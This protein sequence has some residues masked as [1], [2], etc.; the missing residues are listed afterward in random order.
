MVAATA[1]TAANDAHIDNYAYEIDATDQPGLYRIDWPNAAF[2][3]AY[4]EV[5]LSVVLSGSF[6]EHLRVE[7]S[8]PVD[9]VSLGGG[10]AAALNLKTAADAWS[11]T[12]GMSGT[13]LPAAVAGDPGGLPL[14][15]AGSL[16]LDT[17]LANTNEITVARMGALT[18]WIDGGRLDL[19]LDAIKAVTDVLNDPTAAAIATEILTQANGIETGVTLKQALQRIGAS[20]AGQI[21]GAG[22]GTET[23]VGMDGSTT[24]ITATVD[25]AGNRTTMAYDP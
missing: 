6:T 19:L 20:T 11:A 22:T 21:S 7:L 17:K 14:S 15:T 25:A 1:H 10:V 8:A 23:I 12:R 18:D 16:D 24:R 3:A 4:D 2:S 13:A 9:T 5:I